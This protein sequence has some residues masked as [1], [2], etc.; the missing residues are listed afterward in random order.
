AS[1]PSGERTPM[2]AATGP[3]AVLA[4]LLC[5][6]GA[7]PARADQIPAEYRKTVHDVLKWLAEQQAKDGHWEAF[8]GQYPITMT[9]MAGMALLCEGSTLREGKYK[10]HLRLSTDFLMS[11][12]QPNGQ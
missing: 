2:R 4:G 3:A 1:L 5:L 6:G 9:A 8:G 10:N 11:R 12:A 7:T